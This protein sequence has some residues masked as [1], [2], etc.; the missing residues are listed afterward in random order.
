MASDLD[1]IKALPRPDEHPLLPWLTAEEIRAKLAKPNG[2]EE[3]EAAFRT[4]SERVRLAF[5]DPLYHG[6]PLDCWKVADEQ[7]ADP[8]LDIQVNFGWNRGGGKTH[9]AL[10]LLCEAARLYP[11]GDKGVYLVLGE[12]ESSSQSVQQP[13]V[14]EFL[15]PYILA[16]N[17]K[18]HAIYKVNHS[19]A[20]GFTEGLVVIPAG[21]VYD[22]HGRLERYAGF[23][24]IQFDTYKGDPGKYEGQEFGGRV[25]IK[26]RTPAGAPILDLQ[27]RRDGSLV[28]NVAVVADE[29]LALAWFRMLAR[30]VRYRSGKIIW[31][32][33]PIHGMTP[34][35]K[36]V[37]GTLRVETSAPAE[38]LPA[39]NVPGCG[40]GHMPVSGACSWP[41]AKAVYF[42]ISR[43]CV[44]NYHEIVRKDCE[45]RTTE[46]IERIA[47]GYSR[48][49]VNRQFGN[50]GPWNI[51]RPEQ[52]PEVG[53]DYLVV[54]PSPDRPYF[55][56]YVRVTPGV[57]EDK[58]WFY[59]WRDWPDR[60]NYGEWAVPTVRE[61]TLDSRKGWDGDRGPA[62]NNLNLGYGNYKTIWRDIER[63][64]PEAQGGVER[65]PKRRRMQLKLAAG[66]S[67][68]MDI[69]ERIIDSRAGPTPQLESYGQTCAV[70]EFA[71]EHTDP[72]T[73]E[74]LPPVHFRMA[75][76]DKIDLNLIRDL[77][78]YKRDAQ[79]RF[80]QA[81]RLYVTED[82]QQLIWALENYT[83]LS[84]GA[85]AAKDPIDAIRYAAGSGLAHVEEGMALRSVRPG[86]DD[87][88]DDE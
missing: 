53:T 34:A 40:L 25:A 10:K 27:A 57:A 44:N 47:Y 85:G 15:K 80:E 6:L 42:H 88:D 16:L 19:E 31:A 37:V 4:Y 11:S 84:G 74:L 39:A 33:T 87:G 41:R 77:L 26:G 64:F 51:I 38:L 20:N 14:W 83:G 13:A 49:N 70:Q 81:P 24:K 2:R 32:Y 68:Q 75:A 67:A 45:G 35:I 9:R 79:G 69:F 30:R 43:Q 29:G 5:E 50:F 63:V 56:A 86:V 65:D 82:C 59:F 62:Q 18:R 12:T 21:P 7:L 61:T 58:P 1:F 71:R 36:E 46:Y 48:D 72:A 23:S 55:F 76:G 28:Q 73:G 54:D 66:G 22:E 60:Q 52:L 8:E 78:E 17:G 3:F